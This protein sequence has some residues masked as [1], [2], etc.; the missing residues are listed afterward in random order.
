M[1]PITLTV[2]ALAFG[3]FAGLMP[4]AEQAVKD[5]YGGLKSLIKVRFSEVNLLPVEQKPQFKAKRDSFPEDLKSAGV[6]SS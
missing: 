4:R 2:A 5:A 3:A 6:C 1:E